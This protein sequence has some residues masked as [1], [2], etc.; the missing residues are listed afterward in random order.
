MAVTIAAFAVAV[1]WRWPCLQMA[2]RDGPHRCAKVVSATRQTSPISIE[3]LCGLSQTVQWPDVP[4]APLPTVRLASQCGVVIRPM[5]ISRREQR[6]HR[7]VG[8]DKVVTWITD[9]AKVVGQN[10]YTMAGR[11]RFGKWS[12]KCAASRILLIL[13][14]YQT[15]NS[16]T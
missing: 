15:L 8:D 11:A 9:T 7:Y 1:K 12:L 16:M 2:S 4:V 6:G 5:V 13:G 10:L 3:R 14:P